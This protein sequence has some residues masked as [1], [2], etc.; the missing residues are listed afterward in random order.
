VLAEDLLGSLRG[1]SSMSMPPPR[2][3]MMTGDAAGAVDQDAQIRAR[4][5]YRALLDEHAADLLAFGPGL[6]RDHVMPMI[7][8][9][10]C[11]TSP[12]MDL[13]ILDAA[14]LPRPPH[15]SEP[16]RR[17]CPPAAWRHRRLQPV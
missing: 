12:R 5:R 11:S 15:E 8:L 10:S 3:A 17:N 9:A 16:S 13:A 6:M 14:A 7:C 4:D 1:T 2:C